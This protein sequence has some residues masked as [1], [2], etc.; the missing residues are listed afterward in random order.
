MTKTIQKLPAPEGVARV[1]SG[2]VQFGEDWPGVFFRGDNAAMIASTLAGFVAT[3][4]D[5][6]RTEVRDFAL[7]GFLLSHARALAESDL[8]GLVSGGVASI[9]DKMMRVATLADMPPVGGVQ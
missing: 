8:T 5:E 7:Y 6:G 4:L 3:S 9:H 1:E 2:P